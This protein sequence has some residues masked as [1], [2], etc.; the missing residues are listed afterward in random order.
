M[1]RS[2]AATTLALALALFLVP[3]AEATSVAGAAQA[4]C[5]KPAKY[6]QIH[7]GDT[8]AQVKTKAGAPQSK[9][10]EPGKVVWIYYNCSDGFLWYY[11]KFAKS[12]HKV[13][14]KSIYHVPTI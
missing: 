8:M 12:S 10:K 13:V 5:M 3:V 4:K 1:K 9:G 6:K 2:L 14:A 11:I 7:K